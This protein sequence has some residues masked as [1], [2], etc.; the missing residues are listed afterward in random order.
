MERIAK[1][2]RDKQVCCMDFLINDVARIYLKQA[3]EVEHA[4]DNARISGFIFCTYKISI[5]LNTDVN[6]LV[7][8]FELHDQIFILKEDDVYKLHLT[9]ENVHKFF[10]S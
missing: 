8:L 5:I 2:A 6:S 7:E 1:S 10:L 9:K 4:Y 3:M